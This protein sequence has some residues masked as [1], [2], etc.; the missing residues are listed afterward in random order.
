MLYDS[1]YTNST[2]W[3]PYQIFWRNQ[4]VPCPIVLCHQWLWRGLDSKDGLGDAGS[5][6]S[7]A[8]LCIRQDVGGLQGWS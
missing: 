1:E 7:K 8:M 3:E 6:L 5:L 4:G 2:P